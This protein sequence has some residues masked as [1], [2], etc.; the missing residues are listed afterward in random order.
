MPHGKTKAHDKGS[1]PADAPDPLAHHDKGGDPA[2]V[3]EPSVHH[4]V[5]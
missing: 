2:N 4:D 5:V 1:G 3:P